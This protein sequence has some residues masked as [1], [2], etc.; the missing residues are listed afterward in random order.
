VVPDLRVLSTILDE[1][2]VADADLSRTQI[3]SLT[4]INIAVPEEGGWV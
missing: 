3:D 2:T 4:L 1:G